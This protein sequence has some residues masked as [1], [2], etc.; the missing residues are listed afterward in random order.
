MRSALMCNDSTQPALPT[1]PCNGPD[2]AGD[3]S[4]QG[5]G[6]RSYSRWRRPGGAA[7][8][9][10]QLYRPCGVRRAAGTRRRRHACSSAFSA[11]CRL[12]TLPSLRRRSSPCPSKTTKAG[13]RRRPRRAEM[14][15]PSRMCRFRRM[16][17]TASPRSRSIPSTMGRATRH[18]AQRLEYTASSTGSPLPIKASG[19]VLPVSSS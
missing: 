11:A 8:R 2:A 13:T 5:T 19:G 18:T 15:R 17:R 14:A 7:L 4:E 6:C 16:T 10:R 3:R 9:E 12:I 1:A